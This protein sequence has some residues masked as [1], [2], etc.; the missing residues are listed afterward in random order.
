MIVVGNGFMDYS[1]TIQRT[2]Q[3]IARLVAHDVY[4]Y[5][6]GDVE[7]MTDSEYFSGP[8]NESD[9]Q[10]VNLVLVGDAH[11]N[12]LTNLVLSQTQSEGEHGSK[13]LCFVM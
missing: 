6:R 3:R 7:I 4:Q 13:G 9:A 1:S 5:G 12:K 11:Q 2:A 10:K 8:Y